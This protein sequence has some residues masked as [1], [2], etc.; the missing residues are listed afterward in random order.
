MLEH[1]SWRDCLVELRKVLFFL[2]SLQTTSN[3]EI[4][5]AHKFV[6]KSVDCTDNIHCWSRQYRTSWWW[7]TPPLSVYSYSSPLL[8]FGFLHVDADGGCGFV[9][10]PCSCVC[11]TYKELHT[12]VLCTE[13]WPPDSILGCTY[14]TS[15]H[16]L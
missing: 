6:P 1:L 5:C 2:M 8:L 13:L 9:L 3:N 7:R 10:G 4:F 12:P 14:S 16:Y 15:W 11:I